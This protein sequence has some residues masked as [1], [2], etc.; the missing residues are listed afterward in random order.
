MRTDVAVALI[1][2]IGSVIIALIS[3]IGGVVLV[4]LPYLSRRVKDNEDTLIEILNYDLIDYKP[5]TKAYELLLAI[6]DKRELAYNE[7]DLDQKRRLNYLLDD[8]YLNPG[9][10]GGSSQFSLKNAGRK[11]CEIASLTPMADDLIEARKVLEKRR[12]KRVNQR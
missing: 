10:E 11:L 2:T 1:S 8:G 4:Y 9:P 5:G 3:A 7:H 12:R 6:Q